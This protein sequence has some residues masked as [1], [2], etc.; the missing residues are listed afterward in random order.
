MGRSVPQAGTVI[1]EIGANRLAPSGYKQYLL[2]PRFSSAYRLCPSAFMS[3]THTTHVPPVSREDVAHGDTYVTT[4]EAAELL[5]VTS[6]AIR[7]RVQ[8]GSLTA[9]KLD[10]QNYIPRHEIEDEI[11][12]GRET[13]G[14]ASPGPGQPARAA[15]AVMVSDAQ[16]QV[17]ERQREEIDRAY[18]QADVLRNQL[19]VVQRSSEQVATALYEHL[20]AKEAEVQRL[21]RLLE[22][23]DRQVQEL[24]SMLQKAVG[25]LTQ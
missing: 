13:D 8:R 23:K 20:A 11:E 6:S 10:G 18:E 17:I 22:E 9:Y 14:T 21:T 4:T 24:L 5:G 1:L 16:R 19:T 12:P 25:K 7:K 15:T 3:Y 2:L